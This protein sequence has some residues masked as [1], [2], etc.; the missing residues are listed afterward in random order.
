MESADWIS[1]TLGGMDDSGL[2]LRA[3]GRSLKSTNSQLKILST[4]FFGKVG[5]PLP[6]EIS[7]DALLKDDRA[8]ASKDGLLI[9]KALPAAVAEEPAEDPAAVNTA[10]S[11]GRRAG[12]VSAGR[13]AES[14]SSKECR[15][16]SCLRDIEM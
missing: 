8:A 14:A 1:N 7:E 16:V 9:A 15:H 5:I 11:A 3:G 2:V 13:R 12:S 10:V 4:T 6:S